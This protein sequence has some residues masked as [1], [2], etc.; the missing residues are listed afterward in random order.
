MQSIKIFTFIGLVASV[1]IASCSQNKALVINRGNI[2]YSKDSWHNK[3]KYFGISDQLTVKVKNTSTEITKIEER[4]LTNIVEI[5]DSKNN[6]LKKHQIIVNEGDTLYS[7]SKKHSVILNDLI[8]EN[9][10][11]PPYLLKAG[12]VLSLPKPIYHEVKSG[13]TIY[14]IS[15]QYHVAINDLYAFNDFGIDTNIKIGQKIR[16]SQFSKTSKEAS[17]QEKINSP[18]VESKDLPSSV[19]Q[20][21]NGVIVENIQDSSTQ[22]NK[23]IVDIKRDYQFTM[24]T[25]GTIISK[26][27]PKEGGLYNDGIVI[28]ANLASD[29]VAS[30]SGTIAYV[31]NQIKGYGNL[32]IVKHQNGWITAYGHLGKILAKI[33]ST[34]SQGKKIAE[35]GQSGNAKITQLY[36]SIRRG[37]D[38]L[39]PE[40]YIADA[41]KKVKGLYQLKNPQ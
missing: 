8:I 28:K 24:P 12:M 20:N 35:V 25:K 21:N 17:N 13:E 31:G 19:N 26:F 14:S 5:K 7:L 33:G 29:V 41:K 38:A 23:D 37:R 15:R 22:A 11:T 9:S 10:L 27:G 18:V 32:I 39:D 6:T 30:E 4:Q 36:F 40:V 2:K 3:S 1:F 16:I 34:V